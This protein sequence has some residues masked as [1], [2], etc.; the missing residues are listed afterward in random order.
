MPKIKCPYCGN[1]ETVLIVYGDP[2]YKL[3]RQEEEGKIHLGGCVVREDNPRRYCKNCQECFD[4]N[5]V[6][7]FQIHNLH[8]FIGGYS[9]KSYNI[10]IN[11]EHS[12]ELRAGLSRESARTV[13]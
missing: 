5:H 2:S 8:F 1:V 6:T 12:V 9:G 10:T 11:N 13:C 7:A 3:I 4:S